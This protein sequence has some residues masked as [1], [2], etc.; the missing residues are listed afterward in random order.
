MENAENVENI[1]N[2]DPTKE[3]FIEM[4]TRDILL[5]DAIRDLIDNSID[6][7]RRIRGNDSLEGL[8]IKIAYNDGEFVI[9][10]NCGGIDIDI[11]RHYALRFGRPKD[12]L[13]SLNYSIGRFGIG[14]K[15]AI[16]KIG[17]KFMITSQD[18]LNSYSISDE[19]NSWIKRTDWNF[20]IFRYEQPVLGYNGTRIVISDLHDSVKNDFENPT[21][22]NE[23]INE[24]SK[25]YFSVLKKG[26]II[27]INEAILKPSYIQIIDN[28]II[29]PSVEIIDETGFS[30]KVIGG[31]SETDPAKAGWYIFCNDRLVIDADKT[32]L[33]GWGGKDDP[34]GHG[35]VYHNNYAMFRGIV[36]LYAE[37]PFSLPL[38]TTK[39]GIDW[40]S[41]I[42]KYL[43]RKMVN[44]VLS[45]TPTIRKIALQDEE[46]Q[47][48]FSEI[49]KESP[50]TDVETHTYQSSQTFQYRKTVKVKDTVRIQYNIKSKMVEDVKRALE[51]KTNKDVGVET[52]NYFYRM[53]CE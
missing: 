50:K 37:D 49:T 41:P 35:F 51:V 7:A 10:D 3:F 32:K 17:S 34:D 20:D 47:T 21:K 1:A 18:N 25:T 16:F 27:G 52:F 6:G 5:V 33:T 9:E 28:E 2:G 11:A 23:L 26:I 15:R 38:T 53:E 39:H 12:A 42:Y 30:G 4:L 22:A 24:I 19:V 31:I 43:K 13:H 48:E 29:S 40:D 44:V 14:M 45:I 36:Y 46:E 8:F